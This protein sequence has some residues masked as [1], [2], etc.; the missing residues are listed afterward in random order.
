MTAVL[1]DPVD[2]DRRTEVAALRYG[3]FEVTTVQSVEQAVTYLRAHRVSAIVID[4]SRLEVPFAVEELRKRTELPIVVV[5]EFSDEMDVVAALDAG[6]DDV[7]GKPI[8]VEEL[9]ARLRA[10]TRRARRSEPVAPVVTEH[11]TI[12]LA[13]RRIFNPSGV[14]IFLTGVEFRVVEILLRHPGH[15]VPR[16]RVIEEIWGPH[17]TKSP[18]NLRVF[19]ARIRQK[20][21]PDPTHPRYLLTVNGLGLVFEVGRGPF[22]QAAD[23]EAQAAPC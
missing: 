1:L 8:G 22:E 2:D 11:F 14:E 13:A 12:D 6:A 17:G 19:V 23:V 5:A 10:V 4:P 21:E 3:G 15:L 20:L 18:N 9:L 16:Q 7:V